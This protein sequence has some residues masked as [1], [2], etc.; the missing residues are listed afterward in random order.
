M[1]H[2]RLSC[3]GALLGLSAA[4]SAQAFPTLP[5]SRTYDV[6]VSE[7]AS[8]NMIRLRDLNQDGDYNDLGEAFTFF[9]NGPGNPSG[10]TLASTNGV[11]CG[12][13]GEIYAVT[14]TS[15]EIALLRDLNGDGDADDAGEASIW[16]SSAGNS[17]GILLGSAQ[18]IAVDSVGRVMVLCAN[19]GA[20]VGLD[21]ILMI[22]DVDNDGDAQ[23]A[24]EAFYWCQV[25]NASGALAH[26]NPTEMALM[27]DGSIVYGDIGANGPIAKGVYRAADLNTD[28]DAND[29]GEVALWWVPPFTPPSSAA[30]YGFSVDAVGN[31]YVTNHSPGGP[32]SIYR[33]FD[34]TPDGM[35]DAT[36]QQLYYSPTT[37]IFWD[38]AMRDDGTLLMIDSTP[39]QILALK[40]LNTDG[41]FGD[42]GEV[43]V[44]WDSDSTGFATADLRAMTMMRAPEL[45]MTSPVQ[46]GNPLSWVMRTAEPFDLGVAF[47]ALTIVP[48]VSLPPWGNLEIDPSSLIL[49][50]LAVSDAACQA[51]YTLNLANDP[52]LVGSYGAQAWCGELS[53]MFLSNPAGLVITP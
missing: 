5:W 51:V 48:P 36:E 11:A 7:R 53:R 9:T 14:S 29:P 43:T 38:L 30:W 2:H 44:A 10:I 20:S 15:D 39:D 24:G 23:D 22:Q 26:S 16:F 50:G 46:I 4:A 47:A 45:S 6:I 40:D 49:F 34:A 41:D 28:G 8:E 3:F 52:A 1:L 35:I 17:S 18:S 31:L 25:P 13:N 42:A 33:A 19:S 32:R 12:L 21:G 37:G 27:P